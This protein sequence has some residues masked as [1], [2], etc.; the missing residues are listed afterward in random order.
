MHKL[1]ERQLRRLNLIEGALP[2]TK[3]QWAD[4][5][6]KV[7]NSY[8]ENDK[9]R[10][11]LDR[12]IEISS[13]ELMELNKFLENSQH[14]A[15]MGH[16]VLVDNDKPMRF[17]K[18]LRYVLGIKAGESA[19][20][21]KEFVQKIHEE[22]REQLKAF[23]NTAKQFQSFEFECRYLH[24]DGQYHWIFVA[25]KSTSV[26][27]INSDSKYS[28]IIMD[29]T[30][31]KEAEAQVTVL[32]DKLVIAAREAGKSDVSTSILHNVG[33][34][35]NSVGV[36]LNMLEETYENTKIGKLFDV[37]KLIEDNLSKSEEFFVQDPKGKLI[38]KYLVALSDN[39]HK[40]VTAVKAEID[41]L[42][43]SYEHIKDIVA[44]QNSIARVSPLLETVSIKSIVESSMK[45][46]GSFPGES[47]AF[48]DNIDRSVIRTNY[49]FEGN[50]SIDKSKVMQILVNLIKNAK[51]S[52]QLNDNAVEKMVS[53]SVI[54]D[55][56][57]NNIKI[58][59]Q[60]NGMGIDPDNI[61]KIFSFGFSTK[62]DGH[63]FGLHASALA[64]IEM[65]GSLIAE[66]DGIGH[67]AK[68][69][70]TLPKRVRAQG[71]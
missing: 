52:T 67:G 16:W 7:N 33:N 66:S 43:R 20:T 34:V 64:A 4:F 53:L 12:S 2:E 29:I 21:L 25:S 45:M 63:G 23:L 44:S 24:P 11:L 58:I 54:N 17:S 55:D 1:L 57:E 10:Y 9:E 39:I 46:A 65:G 27:K 69:I 40:E 8:D 38:P 71:E 14:I 30:T 61:T 56:K 22:E 5:L 28:G 18:E 37:C 70:L 47:G 36:S 6:Q 48:N 42:K 49:E 62:D 35:L 59:I 13:K 19:P 3:Q 15:Q 60:D 50:I 31:R 26:E 41:G 68:F 51:E 32:N